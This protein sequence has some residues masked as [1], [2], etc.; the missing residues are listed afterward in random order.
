MLT[1]WGSKQNRFCDGI[2]RRDFLQVGT[3]GIGGLTLADLLQ[4][5]AQGAARPESLKS[6]IMVYLH[7]GPSHIDTFDMKPDAPA[8]VRGEFTPIQTSLPG[9]HIC[10]HLPLLAKVADKVALIRNMCFQEF[11]DA[12][13]PPLI[14]TGYHIRPMVR[15][16]FGSVV[17]KLRGG[18]VREMP[19]YVAFDDPWSP[20]IASDYLGVAHHPFNPAVELQTLGPSGRMTLERLTDRKELL[21]SFDAL[22]RV[23]DDT[24]GNVGAMDAFQAR[25]LD[26][27]TTPK[28]RDAFDIQKESEQVRAKYGKGGTQ[29][30]QARRLVEAGVQV[31]TLTANQ[32][33]K[34]WH[35]AGPWDHH[36]KV[37]PGLRAE[38]PALDKH[39]YAL[40]TDLYE[41]GLDQDV[42]VVAWGEMGRTPKVNGAA[43]RDHWNTVGFSLVVGGGLKM[44]QVIG[45]T[46]RWAERSAGSPYTPKDLL[47]TLY[48]HVLGIDPATTLPALDGRPMHVLDDHG[49]IGELVGL[50]SIGQGPVSERHY[51]K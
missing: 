37:F 9:L 32:E 12:H 47:A 23:S 26:M 35:I 29:F 41:R 34:T 43:G 50:P 11:A 14:Y 3:L 36:G 13:D 49:I 40:I 16:T 17:S 39:L 4:L 15:P 48:A 42:A 10:E 19:P 21:R 25:A 33:N 30:L 24:R 28:A 20:R 18:A 8:E 2:S 5:Q 7:G 38:L 51:S 31:V 45:A 44:G 6:V 22:Q 1:F 27:V 46:T